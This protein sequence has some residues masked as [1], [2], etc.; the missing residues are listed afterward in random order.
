[1]KPLSVTRFKQDP[2]ECAVAAA[3][4]IANFHNPSIN[5]IEAQEI[6]QKYV[7]KDTSDGLYTGHIGLLLN[8]LGFRNVRIVFCDLSIVDYTWDGFSPA[9]KL[10][11]INRMLKSKLIADDVRGNLVAFR[12]FLKAKYNNDIVIDFRLAKYIT[13]ALDK[14]LPVIIS[15]NWTLL[16]EQPKKTEDG[17]KDFI[18]GDYENHAVC[19]RGY[20]DS[21]VYIVDSQ[22]QYYIGKLKDYA[23]GYYFVPWKDLL[24]VMGT[25]E[26]IIAS[27]YNHE[28]VQKC[29]NQ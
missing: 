1:M 25:G 10:S 12:D 26:V 16:W 3:T 19:V 4:S 15:Y 18:K 20:D 27:N 2:H 11:A 29:T 13:N 8:K 5:Y 7:V 17:V 9:Q 28:L 22:W 14:N 23:S 6:V 21:G 24:T